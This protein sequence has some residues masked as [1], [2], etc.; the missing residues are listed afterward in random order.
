MF[1][2]RRHPTRLPHSVR[3]LA[4]RSHDAVLLETARFD[5]GNTRSLL[6]L[7]PVEVLSAHA[8]PDLPALFERIEHALASGRYVAG[9][10]AYECGAHFALD[11][12]EGLQRTDDLPLAW[13]GVYERPFVFDHSSGKFVGVPPPAMETEP[14][15]ASAVATSDG[16]QLEIDEGRYIGAIERIQIGRASCRERVLFE[17]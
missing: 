3:T 6:F 12:H 8:L 4:A 17:V 2:V 7:S 1:P 10:L 16:L 9:Y 11:L 13:F 5:A 15:P 14:L